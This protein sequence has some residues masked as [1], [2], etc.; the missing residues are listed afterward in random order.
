ME[1]TISAGE[2]QK[3]Y[4]LDRAATGTGFL[5]LVFVNLFYCPTPTPRDPSG[6]FTLQIW[7]REDVW[8]IRYMVRLVN[9]PS[10]AAL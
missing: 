7:H 3:T 4:A 2:R 6:I 5:V 8:L 10:L 1:P 9:T